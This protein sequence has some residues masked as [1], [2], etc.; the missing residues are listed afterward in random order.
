MPSHKPIDQSRIPTSPSVQRVNDPKQTMQPGLRHE[1]G[2]PARVNDSRREQDDDPV[3][4]MIDG[5][6]PSDPEHRAMFRQLN[7]IARAQA[8]LATSVMAHD[9]AAGAP[10]RYVSP[11]PRSY[12]V[13]KPSMSTPPMANPDREGDV[14]IAMRNKMPSIPD[15]ETDAEKIT[16]LEKAD[17]EGNAKIGSLTEALDSLRLQVNAMQKTQPAAAVAAGESA[18]KILTNK[19]FMTAVATIATTVVTVFGAGVYQSHKQ[20]KSAKQQM[21][22]VERAT[23]EAAKEGAQAAEPKGPSVFIV[24]EGAVEPVPSNAPTTKGK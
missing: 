24:R 7:R 11:L 1:V 5:F 14:L 12:D 21:I 17:H 20:E 10:T 4:D 2:P 13:G 3:S 15:G 19:N 22:E 16:R 23:R 9:R 6:A 18:A 8:T